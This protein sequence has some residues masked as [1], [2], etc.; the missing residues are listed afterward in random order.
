MYRTRLALG[1]THRGVAKH[2]ADFSFQIA[3]AGFA[4]VVAD[5]GAN[6]GVADVRL[7]GAEAVRLQLALDQIAACDLRLFLLG[8][9]GKRDHFHAVA[10]RAGNGV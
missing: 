4:R 10:Q 8:V 2:R 6:R 9:A 1:D 3:Y 5:D 7:P